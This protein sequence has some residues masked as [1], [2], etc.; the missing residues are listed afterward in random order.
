MAMS[1]NVVVSDGSQDDAESTC[2]APVTGVPL[3]DI[4]RQMAPLRPEIDA[5]VSSVFDSGQ[6]VLGPEVKTLETKI[7]AFCQSNFA[8]GCASGSDALLL[9]L[10][11]AEVGAGDE[12][13]VPSYTFF[14]TA[15]AVTR[16]GA[17]VV[18]ADIDPVTFNIDPTDVARR[19]T[20][21]TKAIIPVHLFGQCADM[22]RLSDVARGNDLLIVEDAEQAIGAEY[23]GR[24]AGALGDMGCFS[25]Y[26]T[27]NLGG[28]GDGGVLTCCDEKWSDR[29]SLLRVHGMRPRYYHRAIG[30]NSRLDSLQAAVLNVKLPHLE[31]WTDMRIANALKYDQLLKAAGLTD[32]LE[33]PAATV[34]G[35][36]VW[37]QYVIRVRG[38]QRDALRN[39][40]TEARIGTEIY[41]PVPLHR[42]ACFAD[43]NYSVGSLPET[44]RAASE[45]LALPIFP[46]LSD[47]EQRFV[48]QR[49]SAYFQVASKAA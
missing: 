6:F 21:Q 46:E 47:A 45:T 27:K 18:F 42:Q 30:I 8:V 11:A 15:S 43:L 39:H 23:Q 31:Q 26:P 33:L 29:L 14:S 4:Q 3:F 32:H 10:M 7:A 20:K 36:H 28:P 48:V 22:N 17:K 34:E 19:I 41:Y 40:L 37:N 9:A 38:G 24:R 25:F 16:V 2:S 1:D 44:E 35:R 12:V 13:I 5:A 49:I